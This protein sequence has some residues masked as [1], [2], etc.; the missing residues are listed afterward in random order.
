MAKMMEPRFKLSRRL[1]VNIYG[2]PKA[3][4]RA[5][6]NFYRGSKKLSNY[7]MQLLEKQKL[8]AYYGVLEKQFIRYV[9]DAMKSPGITGDVIVQK[10]ERRLDN[11]VYRMGF[12]LSIRE[13]RQMV[14]HG[15]I[16]VNG[17]KVDI[18]SYSLKVGDVITLRDKSK[19]IDKYVKNFT[20]SGESQFSYIEKDVEKLFGKFVKLPLREEVPI[21]VND[22]LVVEFYS[23]R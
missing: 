22:Q 19:N 6:A 3:M 23:Q 8:R 14:N 18:P 11:M 9:K 7:G 20:E 12:G 13:A 21:E 16:L 15:H 10:L 4:N 1:G 5:G 17:D 2:H